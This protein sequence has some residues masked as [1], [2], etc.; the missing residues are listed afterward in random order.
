MI[1]WSDC[2]LNCYNLAILFLF[3]CLPKKECK[4]NLRWWGFHRKRIVQ[5]SGHNIWSVFIESN[6]PHSYRALHILE[7]HIV[8]SILI[9]ANEIST[10]I[11]DIELFTSYFDL[12]NFGLLT[13]PLQPNRRKKSN[14]GLNHFRILCGV[15]FF[16]WGEFILLWMSVA[17]TTDS[18][19]NSC[20]MFLWWIIVLAVSLRV[21]F[22][23]SEFPLS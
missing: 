8:C 3:L 23:S 4:F 20:G 15:L 18:A 5:T 6:V 14:R 2:S 13:H 21:R 12:L 11:L 7:P 1:R 17:W 9:A 22:I 10:N 19:H 16:T